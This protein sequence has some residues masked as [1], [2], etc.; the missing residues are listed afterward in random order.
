MLFYGH[1]IS[2]KN[3]FRTADAF[4]AERIGKRACPTCS[5]VM[6]TVDIPPT[7]L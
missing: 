5:G 7:L 3:L 6:L 2:P 4:E 1:R